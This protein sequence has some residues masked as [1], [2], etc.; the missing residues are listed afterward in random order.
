MARIALRLLG[1]S[2]AFVAAPAFA[3]A[4]CQ[5]QGT[6]EAWLA[7]F[8]QEAA[9]AGV[10]GRTIGA[11][12]NG[13]T[14]DAGVIKRDRSQKVFKQSFEQFSGRMVPPRLK[15][16]SSMLR[17]HQKLL[18]GIETEFGVPGAVVVAIWALETDFGANRGNL[19][20]LRSLATLAFDCRRSDFFANELMAALMVID[21][22]DLTPAQMRGGW[23]GELGQTQFLPSSYYRFAVD[24]DGNGRRDLIGS[25][26]DVLASTANYL[27]GYGWQA[28]GPWGEGTANF[29]VIKQWNKSTVY[30]QTVAY[31]ASR[32][33]GGT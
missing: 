4:T 33:A 10:S 18:A 12:L 25:V 7:G 11:A 13:V 17:Q 14:Y 23:A 26:P 22:G 16:A 5:N 9:A 21:R 24:F 27:K 15:K 20:T 2:L 3:A 31:F 28:G 19:E 1:L 30:S 29:G 6:F 32:L 8:K